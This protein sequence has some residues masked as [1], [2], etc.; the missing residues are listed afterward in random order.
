[1]TPNAYRCVG[2]SLE[3]GIP[4]KLRVYEGATELRMLTWPAWCQQCEAP[5]LAEYLPSPAAILAEAR[6]LRR[7]DEIYAYQISSDF[8]LDKPE[9]L[10]TELARLDQLMQW[11]RTRKAP[12]QCLD[13]G[14]TDLMFAS[15][16]E[17]SFWHPGCGG[18]L[19][20]RYTVCAGIFRLPLETYSSEGIKLSSRIVTC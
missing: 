1:M 10:P 3:Y 15:H 6:A 16:P 9:Y 4:M 12:S 13:C 8:Y 19:Q 20:P 14:C 11:R 7:G 17:A 18:L 2:C 5:V